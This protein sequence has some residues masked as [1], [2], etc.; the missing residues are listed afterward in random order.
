MLL[1]NSRLIPRRRFLRAGAVSIGLP[2]LDAMLPAGARAQR[3]RA[4]LSPKRIL[5]IGRLLG[6]HADYFFPLDTG[7]SFTPSRYLKLIDRHRGRF[8]VFSGLSHPGYPNAHHCEAGLFTGV[9]AE[10]IQRA[11]DIRNTQSLDQRISEAVGHQTRLSSLGMGQLHVAPMIYNRSGNPIPLE[12]RPEETFKELFVDGSPD[13]VAREVARLRDGLSVLDQVRDQLRS[14]SRELGASDRARVESLTQSIREAEQNLHQNEAWANTPKPKVNRKA[15][16][17]LNP[18]WASAQRM[19]YDLTC[20]AF[21]TDSTRVS[22]IVEVPGDP[23]DAPGSHLGHHDASHHGKEPR[24]IAELALFEEEETRNFGMLLDQLAAAD[25]DHSSLLDH[26]TVLWAS[27]LGN[28][29][30]HASNNLPILLAGGGFKHAGHIAYAQDKAVPLS[31]LYLSLL[32]HLDIDASSFGTST[33]PIS[34][35]R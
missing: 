19:R 22:V 3:R 10:R 25:Q 17:Y 2:L 29:S 24:K 27:N 35:I 8:T 16:D 30:A 15:G 11:D 28:P 18:K 21:Q 13:R 7:P 32:H 9:T 4:E 20:L 5:L 6:T 33:G 23:G 12:P 26:T 14:L 34:E 1:L 31:N